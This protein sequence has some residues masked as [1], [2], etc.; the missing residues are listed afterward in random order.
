MNAGFS[1]TGLLTSSP[2]PRGLWAWR[3][4]PNSL[5][6]ELEPCG[7]FIVQHLAEHCMIKLWLTN[8]KFFCNS[9]LDPNAFDVCCCWVLFE[10]ATF[11]KCMAS[12][13]LCSYQYIRVVCK[14]LFILK[15]L[16]LTLRCLNLHHVHFLPYFDPYLC[17]V[18]LL[19]FSIYF[20]AE[21]F[22]PL[23]SWIVLGKSM[24]QNVCNV[25]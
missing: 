3:S 9:K 15:F 1:T 6:S 25:S 2:R 21:I 14:P 13:A 17:Q 24:S 16:H 23:H 19:K 8:C 5:P 12:Y 20:Y 11:V 10:C 4:S 7:W 22:F 18:M